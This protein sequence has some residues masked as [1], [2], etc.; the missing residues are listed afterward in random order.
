MPLNKTVIFLLILFIELLSKNLAFGNFKAIETIKS[1]MGDDDFNELK[2]TF[3]FIFKN[4]ELAYTLFGEKPLSFCSIGSNLFI[5]FYSTRSIVSFWNFNSLNLQKPFRALEKIK[6]F[7]SSNFA[8][9]LDKDSGLFILINKPEFTKVFNENLNL[10]QT[11]LKQRITADEFIEK[12]EKK[13]INFP[14]NENHLITGILLG[15]G[16]HNSIIFVEEFVSGSEGVY[17]GIQKTLREETIKSQAFRDRDERLLVVQSVNFAVDNSH[18]KPLLY[19]RS[20]IRW[21]KK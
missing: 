15:Y 9:I 16:T 1:E 21:K 4:N 8:L 7:I 20:I 13:E 12:L 6:K 2:K 18:P 19:G 10:I 11:T 17:S 3:V 14:S 5:D